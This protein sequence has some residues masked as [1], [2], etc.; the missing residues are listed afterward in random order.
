MACEVAGGAGGDRKAPKR[1]QF[2]RV[3]VTGT[4]RLRTNDGQMERENEANLRRVGL[5]LL[6]E[7]PWNDREISGRIDLGRYGDPGGSPTGWAHRHMHE[8]CWGAYLLVICVSNHH[9]PGPGS[10]RGKEM[11]TGRGG[12]FVTSPT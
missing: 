4:L 3:L 9:I 7:P 12:S 8:G 6:D 1:S 11:R 5:K 10:S 2:A